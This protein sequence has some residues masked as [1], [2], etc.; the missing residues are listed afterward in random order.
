[1]R[2]LRELRLERVHADLLGA[3][4]ESAT[5]SQIARRWGFLYLGRFAA[6]YREKFGRTPSETLHRQT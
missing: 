3:A 1:M 4:W 6:S 5:V 2:Y